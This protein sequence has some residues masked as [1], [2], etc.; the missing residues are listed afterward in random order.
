M[1][2]QFLVPALLAGLAVLI[3]PVI[4]HLT[5]RQ[6]SRVVEFPS[7]MFLERI[8]YRSMR[9]RKIRN[10]FLLLVRA[11]ALGLLVVA[12]ARPLFT[13]VDL[14]AGTVLGPRDVVV[15]LDRSY[16]MSLG[17]RWSRAVAAARDVVGGL[18][19][20]D[21]A[22]LIFMD[23]RAQ[24]VV[25]S[26]S[27]VGPLL[28]ELDEAQVG[29]MG[30]RFGPS[31]K[32]AESILADSDLPNREVVFISDFQRAGWGGEEDVVFPLGTMIT[33][34]DVS[35]DADVPDN[36]TVAD[37]ELR[38]DVFS[39]RER[40]TVGARITRV[41]GSESLA[42]PVTLRVDGRELGRRMVELGPEGAATVA[43]EPFTLAEPFTA[44][45]VTTEGDGFSVDDAR[46]FVASPGRSSS[47]LVIRGAG[48]QERSTLY[49][50]RAL[51]ISSGVPYRADVRGLNALDAELEDRSVVIVSDAALSSG[52]R[53]ES[54][55]RYLDQGGGVL[56]ILG[57]S[58]RIPGDAADL[59]PAV[60]SEPV[61][62]R[63]AGRLGYLDYS[64]PV[65][66]PFGGP[67]G[68]DFSRA[69]FYRYRRMEPTD[70]AQVLAR[71][72]DGVPAM[73]GGRVGA[74]RVV[75]WASSADNFW[76]DLVL[77]PLFLPLLHQTVA[78]L[79]NDTPV[80]D[81]YLAGDVL[82]LSTPESV[83]LRASDPLPTGAQTEND[84]VALTPSGSSVSVPGGA[85]QP[86]LDLDEQGFYQIRAPGSDEPRPVTVAVNVDVAESD[87]RSMDPEE[88]VLAVQSTAA[89]AEG[90]GEVQGEMVR[91]EDLERRQGLWRFLLVAA[92][93]L[94]VVET[95]LSNRLSRGK[96]AGAGGTHA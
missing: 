28:R 66:E 27:D 81:A 34:V 94:L 91:A 19:P 50:T 95:V 71:F 88:L 18:Q 92:F 16:S 15:L 11:A 58:S 93:V 52:P 55:R 39:G 8:P 24:A 3:V 53:A 10:W 90:G 45:E 76:N 30:T 72:D 59:L 37:L 87:L 84:R 60:V 33:P 49:L 32:L 1:G 96:A 5:R 14:E 85:A 6:R 48:A 67:D 83:G 31:L 64:H 2:L 82:D 89:T 43:F 29:S 61:D 79:R 22:S 36:V 17:D 77:Q 41:G 74:G 26:S 12:F 86:F 54:L 4:I 42:V 9:R 75:V 80:P 62:R 35:G 56:V 47:V 69:R 7:L 20:I 21:R 40:L 46:R 78:Y 65:L 13:D 57:E 70:S 25:R 63:P 44:G 38:R 68:G 23:A 51:G 73:V